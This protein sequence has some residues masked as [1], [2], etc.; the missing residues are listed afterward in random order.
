M[1]FS[2]IE[3]LPDVLR[4]R[5]A[6]QHLV[7]GYG[8]HQLVWR[9]FRDGDEER[10]RDFLYRAEKN[11]AAQ[12]RGLP[13]FYAV[14]ARPPEAVSGVF[15][16][17]TKPYAPVL[18]TGEQ[19]AFRLR[20]NACRAVWHDNTPAG[21]GKRTK[22]QDVVLYRK[23]QLRL[24]L[25]C[26]EIRQMPPMAEIIHEAGCEWLDAQGQ[27]HG[28]LAESERLRVDGYRTHRLRKRG[29]REITFCTLDFTGI[30]EVRSPELFL[31]A[32]LS[33]LGHQKGFGCGLML[34]RRVE[35]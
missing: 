4:D 11:Q 34:V 13:L 27:R 35:H 32:L 14:S 26:G 12:K 20:A 21:R 8:L 15:R 31:A 33:G 28:F 18:R 7:G 10:T 3:V 1:Y 17:D 24:R 9:A 6:R 30:L 23:R 16:V 25:E 22:R 2:R 29:R 19:L 5:P